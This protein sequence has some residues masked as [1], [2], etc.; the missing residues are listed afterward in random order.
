M[1]LAQATQQNKS[2]RKWRHCARAPTFYD[3]R[4]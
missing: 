1:T 3:W 2:S 4:M